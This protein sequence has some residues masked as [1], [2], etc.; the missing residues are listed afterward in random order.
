MH[1]RKQ[2]EVCVRRRHQTGHLIPED[3]ARRWTPVRLLDSLYTVKRALTIVRR[4]YDRVSAVTH[5][6]DEVLLEYRQALLPRNVQVAPREEA[7][8]AVPRQVVHPVRVFHTHACIFGTRVCVG[9][10]DTHGHTRVPRM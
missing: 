5:L 8:H 3:T 2:R 6:V 9:V 10:F 1:K 4:P 7:R